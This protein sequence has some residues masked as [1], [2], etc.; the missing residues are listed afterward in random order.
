MNVACHL[1]GADA[2]ARDTAIA[3]TAHYDHLGVSVPD[4]SGD[5]IYNGFSDNAAGVAMLLGIAQAAARGRVPPLR[6]SVLFLFFSGEERGLLGS[7]HFVTAPPWPLERMAAVINLDAGAPP[8]APV[9]WRLAGVD[10]SGI[11]GVARAAPEPRPSR[12][13]GRSRPRHH[14]PI[15]TTS[16]S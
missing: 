11:G 9:S 12:G 5:S 6:H 15:R 16:R 8:G 10:S 1:S 14:G 7:D 13:V 2:G 3:F 4:A